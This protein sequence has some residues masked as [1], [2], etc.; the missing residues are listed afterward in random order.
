MQVIPFSSRRSRRTLPRPG[1]A[2]LWAATPRHPI[3][4]WANF[5]SDFVVAEGLCL[6]AHGDSRGVHLEKPLMAYPVGAGTGPRSTRIARG[7]DAEAVQGA[8]VHVQL[9]RDV[10]AAQGQIHDDAVLGRADR[11]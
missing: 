9:G 5:G 10:G 4:L 1:A 11:I 3:H 2:F 7:P 8:G 6:L